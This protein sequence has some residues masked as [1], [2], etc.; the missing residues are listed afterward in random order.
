MSR[1]DDP[2]EVNRPDDPP[3]DWEPDWEVE[4]HRGWQP[5]APMRQPLPPRRPPRRSPPPPPDEGTEPASET[6]A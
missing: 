1:P 5:A 4:S 3:E 2:P 6:P